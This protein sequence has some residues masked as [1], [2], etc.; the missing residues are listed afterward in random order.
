MAAPDLVNLSGLMDNAKCF[1][2]VRQH[3]WPEGVRC[4]PLH[5]AA[6]RLEV[7][8][9]VTGHCTYGGT[10]EHDNGPSLI[11]CCGLVRLALDG[12]DL[13][14]CLSVG[15]LEPQGDGVGAVAHALLVRRRGRQQGV[16]DTR[17]VPKRGARA[18]L[19]LHPLQLWR[20]AGGQQ[21]ADRRD[22]PCQLLGRRGGVSGTP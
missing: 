17:R 18:Q 12:H 3:R 13:R 10:I 4:L 20:A 19:G 22:R 11:G 6:D 2:F 14:R 21:R 16:Q 9:L 5:L 8:N 7:A 15:R 1:A